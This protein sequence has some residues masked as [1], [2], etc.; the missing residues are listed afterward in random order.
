MA[1]QPRQLST[2]RVF[3]AEPR[4]YEC[5]HSIVAVFAS[6]PT[7]TLPNTPVEDATLPDR[8]DTWPLLT[9]V[10]FDDLVGFWRPWTFGRAIEGFLL[11]S[12]SVDSQSGPYIGKRNSTGRLQLSATAEVHGIVMT[13]GQLWYPD[14]PLP[15]G[16]LSANLEAALSSGTRE[17]GFKIYGLVNYH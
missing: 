15:P 12:T 1:L 8:G 13:E 6:D 9:P 4:T 5:S 11:G 2:D 17:D 10:F 3:Y 7:I 16:E 14:I